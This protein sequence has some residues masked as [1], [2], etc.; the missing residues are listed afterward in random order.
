MKKI[1]DY[2]LEN[3][4]CDESSLESALEEQLNLKEKGVSKLLGSILTDSASISLKDLDK[5]LSKMHIDILANS[6]LFQNISKES[7]KK[8]LS[9]AEYKVLP[10]NSDIFNQG[11]KSDSFFV[12]ISL[13][14]V[15]S[16]FIEPHLKD[17]ISL[18]DISPLVKDLEKFHY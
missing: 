11:E 8:T 3:N 4:I 14:P 6:A 17:R 2:L 16:K 12:V 18:W 10:G 1:G 15:K 7:I 13:F 5:A 9:Q